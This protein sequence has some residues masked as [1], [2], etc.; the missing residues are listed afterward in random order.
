MMAE[1]FARDTGYCRGK[2]GS[3]HIA[4]MTLNMLGANGIVSAGIPLAT[5]AAFAAKVL[6]N[7]RVSVSF[8]GDGAANEGVFMESLN[9]AATRALPVVFVCENNGYAVDIPARAVTKGVDIARRADGP[10]LP[11]IT[12]DG[13]DVEAVHGAA[14]AAVDR[15][16]AGGGPTLLERK[17][18]RYY[19]HCGIWGD[20]RDADEVAAW[21]A[22]DPVALFS[23]LLR[24]RGM[25]SEA[26]L[27]AIASG[28][29][30]E[31][32]AAVT[33]AEESPVPAP[34][35]AVSDVYCA[36]AACSGPASTATPPPAIALGQ[37]L[38]SKY[39]ED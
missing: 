14:G 37:D 31:L 1:L 30:Q 16:R 11:G 3:M 5:G 27:A 12:V 33:F 29:T 28:L 17:T 25:A 6:G 32:D 39:W 36:T 23:E 22:R 13:Q 26:E 9:I 21:K 7:G 4:D 38:V 24:D 35:E 15:A 34:S 8:F 10:G 18:Y 19:G 20:P 2:G